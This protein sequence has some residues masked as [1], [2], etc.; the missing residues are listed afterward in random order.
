M[1]FFLNI[2]DQSL[3]LIFYSNPDCDPEIVIMADSAN[4]L[5]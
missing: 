1:S 4:Q 3:G 5:Q 2:F